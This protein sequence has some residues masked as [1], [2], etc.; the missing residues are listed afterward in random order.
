MTAILVAVCPACGVGTRATLGW[1]DAYGAVLCEGCTE[2]IRLDAGQLSSGFA[3]IDE[4]MR[5]ID[6]VILELRQRRTA[7]PNPAAAV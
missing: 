3:A 6:R 4:A 2:P 7:L 1:V 5:G